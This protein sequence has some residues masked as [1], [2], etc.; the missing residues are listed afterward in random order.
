MPTEFVEITRISRRQRREYC[1]AFLLA[2]GLPVAIG[3]VLSAMLSLIRLWKMLDRKIG[4]LT[5]KAMTVV[6]FVSTVCYYLWAFHATEHMSHFKVTSLCINGTILSNQR[7]IDQILVSWPILLGGILYIIFN[8]RVYWI[9]RCHDVPF[10]PDP[11]DQLKSR[12]KH[13]GTIKRQRFTSVPLRASQFSGIMFVP[14]ILMVICTR[15]APYHVSFLLNMA[16]LG[17]TN[18]FRTTVTMK[19][20][21]KTSQMSKKDR[22]KRIRELAKEELEARRQVT[23]SKIRY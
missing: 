18:V 12:K 5:L 7:L 8:C 19:F 13:I 10:N 21:F 23:D 17:I 4:E 11:S 20:T 22:Q 2:Y 15:A 14:F 1:G 6:V 3:F 16:T 9:C